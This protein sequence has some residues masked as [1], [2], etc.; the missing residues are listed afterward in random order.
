MTGKKDSNVEPREGKRPSGL[1]SWRRRAK[2]WGL[3]GLTAFM[4]QLC[5]KVA[6]GSGDN[7]VAMQQ[8][9][10]KIAD[11]QKVI[12]LKTGLRKDGAPVAT[13]T[14]TLPDDWEE[15][16]VFNFRSDLQEIEARQQSNVL[17]GSRSW[18]GSPSGKDMGEIRDLHM[19]TVFTGPDA[20]VSHSA[21]VGLY[22]YRDGKP[23][24]C[25]LYLN[26]GKNK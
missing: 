20:W 24:K 14:A 18:P 5:T 26:Q 12:S 19:P 25:A 15:A 11:G 17:V 9:E 10:D 2:A 23:A 6:C 21:Y 13:V 3:S 8:C 1:S 16:K 22:D 7:C 4:P